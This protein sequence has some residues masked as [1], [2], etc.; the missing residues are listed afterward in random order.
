MK[1]S[2]L[3]IG[4]PLL[5]SCAIVLSTVCVKKSEDNA[6]HA[7]AQDINPPEEQFEPPKKS[8]HRLSTINSRRAHCLVTRIC[9]RPGPPMPA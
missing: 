8:T 3:R 4:T 2:S 1:R 5:F 7:I 6:G 9:T